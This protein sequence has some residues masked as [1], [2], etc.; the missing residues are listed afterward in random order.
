MTLFREALGGD[1]YESR[2]IGDAGVR[3]TTVIN[4]LGRSGGGSEEDAI[5]N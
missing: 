3:G 1:R 5:P 2:L 4:E